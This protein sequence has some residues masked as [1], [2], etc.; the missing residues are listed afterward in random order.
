M[1]NFVKFKRFYQIIIFLILLLILYAPFF[2]MPSFCVFQYLLGHK[3]P[4]C[5]MR[6]AIYDFMQGDFTEALHEN[7]TVYPLVIYGFFQCIELFVESERITVITKKTKCVWI[8]S[9][10][11]IGTYRILS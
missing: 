9:I 8:L 7:F 3:C 5:G 2:H 4:G 1:T 10:I 6:H 11:I